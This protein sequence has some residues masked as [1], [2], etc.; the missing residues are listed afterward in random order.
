MRELD[1]SDVDMAVP[2]TIVGTRAPSPMM[3]YLRDTRES[4]STPAGAGQNPK[5]NGRQTAAAAQ[6]CRN[7]T[8]FVIFGGT[9]RTPTC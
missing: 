6:R 5:P 9:E 4:S 7:E 3:G 8:L 2:C 1:V